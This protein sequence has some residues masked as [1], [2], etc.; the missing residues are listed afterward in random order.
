MTNELIALVYARIL[1]WL[2]SAGYSHGI[3]KN[4]IPR[5]IWNT[6]TM[7][8]AP[9][10][11]DFV[12][13]LSKTAASRKQV[14]SPVAENMSNT[15]RPKRSTVCQLDRLARVGEVRGVNSYP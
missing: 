1:V 4:P 10:A 5:K 7:A 9:Y 6:K 13:T 8:V 3:G 15:R 2:T 11:A 12:P 14:E